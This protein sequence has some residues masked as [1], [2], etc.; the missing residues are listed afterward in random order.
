[1]LPEP[2]LCTELEE[3]VAS[4]PALSWAFTED[5]DDAGWWQPRCDWCRVGFNRSSDANALRV[6][7]QHLT[8]AQHRKCAASCRSL[9]TAEHAAG[10]SGRAGRVF[11]LLLKAGVRGHADLP[12][13]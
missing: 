1:M 7:R 6:I 4:N 13:S 2:L 8:S 5:A 9:W 3:L 10:L 12:R 11:Q